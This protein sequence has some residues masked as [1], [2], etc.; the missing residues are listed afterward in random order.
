[1]WSL[2]KKHYKKF[3]WFLSL[4]LMFAVG[5]LESPNQKLKNI[6]AYLD[7]EN[8]V[9]ATDLTLCLQANKSLCEN[10]KKKGLECDREKATQPIQTPKLK[11]YNLDYLP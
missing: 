10:A 4:I 6:N 7:K 2:A 11:D 5:T 3:L 9:L 8:Q 1:M